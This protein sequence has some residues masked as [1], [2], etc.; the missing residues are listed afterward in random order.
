MKA[1][2]ALPKLLKQEILYES[3]F[4]CVIC[5]NRGAQIH[6]IDKN[7][8]N[9][10]RDNLVLLCQDHHDEAH[11][12]RQIS[13]SLTADRVK[14]FRNEWYKKVK[15]IR[16]LAATAEG[17]ETLTNGFLMSGV[18]WGNINYS[19]LMQTIGSRLYSLANRELLIRLQQNNV[20]DSQGLLIKP[21]NVRVSGSYLNNTIY[22]WFDY[23]ERSALHIYLSRL[24]DAF[25]REVSPLHI[26]ESNWNRNFIKTMLSPG[27]FLFL[28]R[29]QYFKKIREDIENAEVKVQTFRR[30]IHFRYTIN[31]RNMFGVT[32]IVSSFSARRTSASLLQVKSIEDEERN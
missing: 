2:K 7:N 9:N 10:D 32:S 1:R 13:L 11:T 19:R 14:F 27:C 8:A 5:Q 31:T 20:L 22:D 29:G 16:E 28:N 30:K 4:R 17:Q 26:Y 25:S 18:S 21:N 24:V 15:D 12:T 3:A 6:H 23:A